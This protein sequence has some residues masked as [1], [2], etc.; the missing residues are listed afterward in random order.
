M[1]HVGGP[2]TLCRAVDFVCALRASGCGVLLS[3]PILRE[4]LKRG[5]LQLRS[6]EADQVGFVL[7]SSP[8]PYWHVLRMLAQ[9]HCCVTGF[10]SAK[11]C[12]ADVS[13]LVLDDRATLKDAGLQVAVLSRDICFEGEDD[14]DS[15]PTLAED[16]QWPIAEIVCGL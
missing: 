7:A 6:V 8:L 11:A 2:R 14:T 12:G 9:N 16:D 1:A 15:N 5:Q 13:T 10:Y 4:A 3:R